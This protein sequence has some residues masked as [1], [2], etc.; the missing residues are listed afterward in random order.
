MAGGWRVI[1]LC[2]RAEVK[3]SEPIVMPSFLSGL[4]LLITYSQLSR[5]NAFFKREKKKEKKTGFLSF[6][7]L[8]SS[9]CCCSSLCAHTV[10]L[11][12]LCVVLVKYLSLFLSHILCK[13]Y[14]CMI[15]TLCMHC[16]LPWIHIQQRVLWTSSWV[17]S[18]RLQ[19]CIVTLDPNVPLYFRYEIHVCAYMLTHTNT[20][21]LYVFIDRCTFSLSHTHTHTQTNTHRQSLSHTEHAYGIKT[22]HD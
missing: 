4:L 8:C 17:T 11:K 6:Q 21:T 7:T 13:W 18:W 5:S 20:H 14:R 16:L 22:C 15:N 10:L 1:F 12:I 19:R 9:N 2:W 3:W